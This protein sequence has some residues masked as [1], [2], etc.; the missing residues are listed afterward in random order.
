VKA[1]VG[2]KV[3]FT[4]LQVVETQ[5]SESREMSPRAAY[6]E[7]LTRIASREKGMRRAFLLAKVH[8]AEAESDEQFC[9]RMRVNVLPGAA[10]VNST[11]RSPSNGYSPGSPDVPPALS[12]GAGGAHSALAGA[13]PALDA[14]GHDGRRDAPPVAR[15]P[16]ESGEPDQR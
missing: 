7:K 2:G 12:N 13:H 4:S 9:K 14:D 16:L 6:I 5:E 3:V 10:G 8:E 15:R 1:P 11:G